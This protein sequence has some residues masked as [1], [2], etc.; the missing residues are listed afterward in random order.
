MKNEYTI[1]NQ[2]GDHEVME[3]AGNVLKVAVKKFNNFYY[4]NP[5]ETT[6]I[7]LYKN[8]SIYSEE[9]CRTN[10]NYN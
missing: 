6:A 5:H 3:Y 10:P 7:A 2:H 8:G 9:Y 4:W 1:V